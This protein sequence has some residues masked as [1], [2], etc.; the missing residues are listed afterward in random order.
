MHSKARQT[1]GDHQSE[2]SADCSCA[3]F[4]S[5]VAVI[6][7]V[8]EFFSIATARCQVD[9]RYTLARAQST[10]GRTLCNVADRV[11]CVQ[12]RVRQG[13]RRARVTGAHLCHYPGPC[14][15]PCTY[16]GE[17]DQP[18]VLTSQTSCPDHPIG[19]RVYE[20]STQTPLA[21]LGQGTAD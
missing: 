2:V 1:S 7:A 12:C 10:E 6:R 14:A 5:V 21:F 20:K 17:I 15:P 16:W 3:Q 13:G 8:C 18:R 19:V 11:A 4:C 9:T